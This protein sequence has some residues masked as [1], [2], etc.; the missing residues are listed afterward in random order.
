MFP[1]SISTSLKMRWFFNL[2]DEVVIR[3]SSILAP[4]KVIKIG[5]HIA[6]Q[7]AFHLPFQQ[8]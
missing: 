5:F 1:S 6:F 7:Q 2:K 4:R 8:A 3:P